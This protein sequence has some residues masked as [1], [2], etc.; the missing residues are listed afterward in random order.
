MLTIRARVLGHDQWDRFTLGEIDANA[1]AA[2]SAKIKASGAAG[3]VRPGRTVLVKNNKT[4]FAYSAKGTKVDPKQCIG[5]WAVVEAEMTDF[6]PACGQ[7]SW[8]LRL[9]SMRF[10][11]P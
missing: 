8:Y 10:I 9:Y 6:T 7:P 1:A 4:A 5:M 11:D 2:F 3:P